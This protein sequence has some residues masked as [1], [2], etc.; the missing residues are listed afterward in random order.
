M[1]WLLN[2]LFR[3]A[4]GLWSLLTQGLKVAL[5]WIGD[6]FLHF[7][8]GGAV[9]GVTKVLDSARGQASTMGVK[10]SST[11]IGYGSTAPSSNDRSSS[12]KASDFMGQFI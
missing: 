7:V 12:A 4:S 11:A 5:G 8:A 10:G 2:L 3:A 1:E 6:G 9:S